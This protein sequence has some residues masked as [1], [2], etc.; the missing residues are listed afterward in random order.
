MVVEVSIPVK[1]YVKKYLIKR[2]G[3]RHTV[4]RTSFLGKLILVSLSKHFTR[5]DICTGKELKY[6]YKLGLTEKYFKL[7]GRGL[8]RNKRFF[9]AECF[10]DVLREDLRQHLDQVSLNGGKVLPELKA[11]LKHY[12]ITEEDIKFESLYKDYQRYCWRREKEE[13]LH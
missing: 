9:L 10:E 2:Y 13:K 1:G 4:S 11:W 12:D 3:D 5:Q 6:S 8:T 7:K